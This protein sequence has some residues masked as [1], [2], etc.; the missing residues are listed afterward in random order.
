MYA[1]STGNVRPGMLMTGQ[2][3]K[4]ALNF[5]AFIVADISTTL[6]DGHS[7]SSLQRNR[8]VWRDLT[9]Q[10]TCL[11]VCMRFS[12]WVLMRA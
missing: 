5:S 9:C 7:T 12:L 1:S 8:R 11:P 4:K 3:P 10:C 6:S 2:Y